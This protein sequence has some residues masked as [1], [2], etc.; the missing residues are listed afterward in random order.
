MKRNNDSKYSTHISYGNLE[1]VAA[2]SVIST[3]NTNERIMASPLAKKM[4][5]E[6]GID[7]R[8]VQG[9]GE[10]GRIVEARY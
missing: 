3:A 6:K 7:L 1:P 2:T 9:S 10:H 5:A 4:A 8:Q